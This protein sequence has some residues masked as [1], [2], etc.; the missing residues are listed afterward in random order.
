MSP[1]VRKNKE[2][3]DLNYEWLFKTLDVSAISFHKMMQ[4]AEK[5]DTKQ[6]VINR[7]VI[8]H[9]SSKNISFLLRHGG[10]KIT[11]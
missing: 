9:S 6:L 10:S 8:I 11:S 4:I 3:G 5:I 2:Y 1:N 7:R